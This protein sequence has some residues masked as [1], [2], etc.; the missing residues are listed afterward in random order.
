MVCA[1]RLAEKLGRVGPDL[2]AR[3]VRLLEAFSLP[4][5]VK[6]QWP[7]DDLI[8]VMRRDKKATNGRLRFVLPTRLGHVEL[9]DGVPEPLVAEVLAECRA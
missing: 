9:V 1:S 2:T 5:T 7:A 4:T 6:P 8:A 3:Q